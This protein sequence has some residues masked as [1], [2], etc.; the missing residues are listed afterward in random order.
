MLY[1]DPRRPFA[2][3]PPDAR[4]EFR[5]PI[6]LESVVGST[7][8]GKRKVEL[9]DI[10]CTGCRVIT[11]L[12]FAVDHY[13]VIT[14]PGLAPLGAQVRWTTILGTGMRF[15]VPLSA[16]VVDRIRTS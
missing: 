1:R 14:I 4:K 15:N 8:T 5:I 3:S 12:D 11:T 13:V 7:R 2:S 16:M 9:V 6:A 10:S